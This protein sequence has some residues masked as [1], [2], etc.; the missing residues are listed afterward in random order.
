MASKK[1]KGKPGPGSK[2]RWNQQELDQLINYCKTLD[3][4]EDIASN[5]G[6]TVKS[7]ERKADKLNLLLPSK[8]QR[9][10]RRIPKNPPILKKQKKTGT[11]KELASQP[12]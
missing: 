7:V 2:K 10:Q 3:S 4:R 1:K 9:H 11:K 6:R 12:G 5:L 8:Y